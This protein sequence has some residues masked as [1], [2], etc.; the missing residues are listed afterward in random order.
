MPRRG[1]IQHHFADHI[2][3]NSSRRVAARDVQSGAGFTLIEVLLSVA[4]IGLIA[5]IGAVVYQQLQNRNALDVAAVT[6]ATQYRRAQA[7]SRA[8]DANTSW[9]VRVDA[10]TITLFQ[11]ASYASRVVT[12]D[13]ISSPAT[14]ITSSG[15]VEVVFAKFTGL[16]QTTGTLTLTGPNDSRTLTLNAQGTVLY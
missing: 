15:F 14:S 11:G 10:G 2:M 5:S 4:L 16:P 6:V 12:F 13:E 7:L 1:F 9:G 8:S 3:H